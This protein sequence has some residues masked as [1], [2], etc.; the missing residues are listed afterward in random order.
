RNFT[1]LD[2]TDQLT[3][4]R[5]VLRN[6]N[7][8]TKQF[9]PRA[10][11]GAISNAKNELITPEQY[12]K[13]QGNYYERQIADIYEAYQKMLRRNQALDFDDLIMET[14]HLFERVPEVLS[15]YQRRFQYIHVDEYQDTNNAQYHLVQQLA[16]KF[17]NLCVVGDSD[18]S[19]YAWRGANIENI[20]S[21]EEDY[22]NA[23]VILLEQNYRST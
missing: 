10:M 11:L 15:Y 3:V 2:T 23:R 19:I 14:T 17:Q 7:V 16:A 21:F 12:R 8:D 9:D 13:N 20:L 1:I 5:Q 22:P 6:L 18:Q 4:M